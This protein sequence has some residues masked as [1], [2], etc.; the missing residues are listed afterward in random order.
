MA[1]KFELASTFEPAGDQP[2][3]IAKLIAGY[4]DGQP[5]QTLLGATGTGKTFTAA[6]VVQQI[7]KPT[8]VLSHNKTLAAQLYKEFRSF[9]PR[10]AVHYFISYYDYYQPEAYIPQRDIYIEKD[11]QI[12]ENIDR[13]RLA[14]TSALVSREDVIIVASVSCIYGLGSPNDYRAMMVR[15]V[16]GTNVVRDALLPKLVDIQYQ[17]NDVA[18]T[19]G[20]FRVRGD[21]VEVWPAYEE[22]GLRIELF[23]DEVDSLAIIN[24]TSGETLRALDEL[25]VYPAKHFVTPEERVKQAVE[26]IRG[27]LEE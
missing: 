17:R 18:F 9:F 2:H 8:L 24:P 27:E 19:R 26:G 15:V 23:G 16:Q 11:A 6:H 20:T 12:N 7:G 1:A 5:W 13:L 10:N 14:A 25:Y 22:F 3:A 21:V 4:R